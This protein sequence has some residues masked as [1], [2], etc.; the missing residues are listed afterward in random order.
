M[1]LI[2]FLVFRKAMQAMLKKKNLLSSISFKKSTMIQNLVN[3]ELVKPMILKKLLRYS[4]QSRKD[5]ESLVK[6]I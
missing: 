1:F 5:F 4:K 2:I 3:K 6:T